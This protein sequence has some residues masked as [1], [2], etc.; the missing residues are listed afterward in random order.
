MI[1]VLVTVGFRSETVASEVG[2][3][4]FDPSS[5]CVKVIKIGFSNDEESLIRRLNSHNTSNFAMIF[6]KAI[7][8]GTHIDEYNIHHYF[9]KKFKYLNKREAFLYDEEILDFFDKNDSILKIRVAIPDEYKTKD[10]RLEQRSAA[11]IPAIIATLKEV[12][13]TSPEFDYRY[14]QNLRF[15]IDYDDPING[16]FESILFKLGISENEFLDDVVNFG[17][18]REKFLQDEES[19]SIRSKLY[20]ETVLARK[21]K[22]LIDNLESLPDKKVLAY[23]VP[24][25]L[26]SYVSVGV[27][28]LKTAGSR[29]TSI[30]IKMSKKTFPEEVLDNS[31]YSEFHEGELDTKANIKS[32][33]AR[34]YEDVGY[35]AIPKASD[36]QNWF[37]VMETQRRVDKIKKAFFKLIRKIK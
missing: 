7:S 15:I 14:Q 9:R 33:I 36:I 21:I 8:G 30:R 32:R 1:Y 34:I 19:R 6:Y 18:T 22:F 13:W 35:S 31:V 5:D 37:E 28:C 10:P 17:N 16:K 2:A 29:I 26:I 25:E 11:E 3:R 20:E 4:R 12:G 27:D 24:P 23:I